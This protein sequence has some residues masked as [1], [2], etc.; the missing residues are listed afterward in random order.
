[1]KFFDELEIVS[2][3]PALYIARIDAI[4]IADLH[5][6]YEGIMAE[7]GIFVP[8][9]QFK[10][11]I[12][13][14]RKIIQKQRA[15]RIVINGDL[16]HEFSETS[17]HEFKEVG[18]LLQF[19]KQNFRDVFVVK[20]NH[21]NFIARVTKKCGI[22]IYDEL[23]LEEFYFLHGHS[24]PENFGEIKCD[25]VILAHEHPAL[26]L[27]DEV[28]AKEKI[29]CFL[30]GDTRDGKKVVVL[31]AF[32]PLAYGS[33]VNTIPKEQ[34]LSPVLKEF[35][36]IDSLNVIGISEEVGALEFPELGRLRR[37]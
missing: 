35:V 34:L 2:P 19:L 21:D 13:T 7:Q 16:K 4:V 32:S 14:L 36:D 27:C 18:E 28:G 22:E 12:A 11:E 6:G 24:V 10:K 25:Y 26:A 3:F 17:Y 1:M 23:Q 33:D 20:G 8:K 37:L 5:L 31:P 15:S 9:V 29:D 30:Y